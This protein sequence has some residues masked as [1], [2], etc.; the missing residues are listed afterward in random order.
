MRAGWVS[1]GTGGSV[2]A[3]VFGALPALAEDGPWDIQF[4]APFVTRD[5]AV[6]DLDMDRPD[7]IAAAKARGQRVLCY[8][9]VGTAE[10]WR[11]DF[12]AFPADVKGPEWRDWPGEY[13]LDIRRHDVL[14]PIMEARFRACAAAGADAIDP[15]N[16]DQQWAGAFPITTA[17]TVAYMQALAQLANGMG[18]EIGQKNNPDAVPDLVGTLDFIVTEGCF[19]DG[20]CEDVLPYVHAGK[21]VHAIEYTD[22]PV[23][24]AAACAYGRQTGIDFILKDRALSGQT[25]HSCG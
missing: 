12:A 21:P 24:F 20:W 1:E 18:L 10:A 25:Y 16:Q 14:L 19:V 15:D 22:T 11:S 2:A 23:D 13:F 6:I 8:V 3:L 9:S 5:V 4:A 7:Q 17:E